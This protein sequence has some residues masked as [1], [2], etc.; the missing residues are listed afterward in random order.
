MA[1]N[2]PDVV[3]NEQ[4]MDDTDEQMAE[5]KVDEAPPS[6]ED[7]LTSETEGLIADMKKKADVDRKQLKESLYKVKHVKEKEGEGLY[8]SLFGMV[9]QDCVDSIVKKE[10]IGL[11]AEMCRF[12]NNISEKML[13]D[14]S[15]MDSPMNIAGL[16]AGFAEAWKIWKAGNTEEGRDTR[17]E[18]SYQALVAAI[19][20]E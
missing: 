18:E 9:V 17:G 7:T 4:A 16:P 14:E 11:T 5:Q 3:V 8:N 15:R 20:A 1:Q 2:L 13:A 19:T 6:Y 10:V 12:R